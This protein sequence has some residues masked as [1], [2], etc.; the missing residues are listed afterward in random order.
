MSTPEVLPPLAELAGK[1]STNAPSAAEEALMRKFMA[2]AMDPLAAGEC[3][4]EGIRRN[5]LYIFTHPEFEPPVCERMQALL[6][7]FPAERAPGARA[8]LAKRFMTDLY[9]R[10]RDRRSAPSRP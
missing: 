2:A 1:P 9:I 3:V 4:L 7:S 5:D 8:M 6:A 10:E